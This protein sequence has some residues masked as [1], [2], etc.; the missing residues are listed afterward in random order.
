MLHLLLGR[1][2]SGKTTFVRNTIAE[3][4]HA[5][6]TGLLLLVPEQYSY[7]S[8]RAMLSLVG[9]RELDGLSIVS[10]TRLAETVLQEKMPSRLPQ[11]DDGMRAVLMRLAIDALGDHTKI[12]E[13][14][15]RRPQ[16][17]QTLVSFAK[18]LKQCAVP[19][20]ALDA[21]M[22]KLSVGA[23]REKVSELSL[24]MQMY[25]TLLHER[26]SDDTD[27]LT[28]LASCISADAAFQNKTVFVDAFAGFTAQ[29]RQV[30]RALFAACRDVYIT[31][32]L[33]DRR[34]QEDAAFG[35][36]DN[37]EREME[38]LKV[39]AREAGAQVAKPVWF[40][41]SPESKPQ[42]LLH[43]ERGLFCARKTPMPGA[44]ACIKMSAAANRAQE[45][46]MVARAIC[47]L[48]RD[49]GYRAREIAVVQRRKDT[50]DF[51]LRTAFQKYGVPYFE[52]RR[53]PVKTQPLMQLTDSLLSMGVSG[54]TTEE[55]LRYLKTGLC[56]LT[57]EEI[58]ALE[59]Y[60]VLWGVDRAQWR[61]DFTAN[62]DGLG[63][64]MQAE[65]EKT[66][67]RLNALRRRAVEPVLRF[68]KTFRTGTGEQKARALFD[69]LQS[70]AVPDALNELAATLRA[71]GRPELAEQQDA[72]WTLLMQMLDALAAA[73]GEAEMEPARFNTLFT[74]L[75]DHADIG[76]LPQGLDTVTLGT[77][78]RIRMDPPRAVFLVGANDGVFPEPPPTDGVFSSRERQALAEAGLELSDTVEYK[79]V[80]ERSFVY[81]AVT[82]PKEKLFVSWS[83]TDFQGNAL[84]PSVLVRELLELFPDLPVSDDALLDAFSRA[85][86]EAS[87][88]EALADAEG[89]SAEQAETL[90]AYFREKPAYKDRLSAL[91]RAVSHTAAAFYDQ[92]ISTRLFGRDMLISASRAERFY[93]CPFG[94]FCKF[95]L[96]LKPLKQAELDPAQSGTIIHY[97]LEKILGE[98]DKQTLCGLSGDELRRLIGETMDAYTQTR[99][100]GKADKDA[101]FLRMLRQLSGTVQEVLLRLVAEFSVCAFI[102]T[103]F[104]LSISPDGDIQPYKLTLKDGG[105]LRIIGSVDRVDTMQKDEKTYLR[106]I[107][108]KSGGKNF[109]LS[110]V[111]S[112][113]NMQMLIYLYAILENGSSVFG[114]TLVP[115]GVLYFPAKEVGEKLPRDADA[116]SVLDA[117]LKAARMNGVVLADENAI[118]GMDRTG[119]GNFIPAKENGSDFKG[120]LLSLDAFS[121]LKKKVDENLTEMGERLHRGEI[122]VLPDARPD[123]SACKYCDYAAVCGYEPGDPAREMQDYGKFDDVKKLLEKEGEL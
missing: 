54:I 74:I 51:H 104:E 88:F 119:S 67:A 39:A 68:R 73:C 19:V 116:K 27:A 42:G 86:S 112:G 57:T 56:G 23:L 85:Q 95:G 13:R 63:V 28:L 41:V 22:N 100:G 14:Y 31:L 50:Y 76:T 93:Q 35:V 18:E 21:A 59:G 123:H 20:G 106:V 3:R 105:S 70:L 48:L 77:A 11:V 58:A 44:V 49:E 117:K 90:R 1:S 38:M 102:P 78:D 94:Y 91:D 64:E 8:E 15:A 110:E 65:Q 107:D 32:T 46:D 92:E 34:A 101:R 111:L 75:L 121:A 99:L 37:V 5:G 98:Y 122:P 47:G 115:A 81:D 2:G 55:L 33:P 113:L 84:R 66:L 69:V 29:E 120:N 89:L 10:F 25:E 109:D 96:A 60:A 17:L 26:F 9:P 7:A 79:A 72:V 40:T 30:L 82:L 12:F 108:Y 6:D 114:E 83:S 16:L 4:L 36:F 24:L 45:S 61:T 118:R 80:D 97:C 71:A 53:Q 62:P 87:A 52:D 103:A 43:L